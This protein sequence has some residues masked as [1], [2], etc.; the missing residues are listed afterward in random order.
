MDD[1]AY[2]NARKEHNVALYEEGRVFY[3]QPEQVRPKEIEHIAGAI[4]GSMVPKS[5]ALPNNPLIFS[6]LRVS[7]LVI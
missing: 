3:S 4:T 7:W 2:N 5:W 1:L 6:R